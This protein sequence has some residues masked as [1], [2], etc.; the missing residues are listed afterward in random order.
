MP[1]S[2]S[3]SHSSTEPVYAA[4]DLG[5]NSFHMIVV[6]R[7]E[8]GLQVIDRLREMVRLADAIDDDG[9]LDT[10]ATE[11][12]IECLRRF[13]ERLRGL[14]ASHVRAVGT[15]TLRRIGEN[16]D[17][18]SRAEDALGLPIEVI[19]G[20]EEARLIYLGV[21]EDFG[22]SAQRQLVIDIGGGSTEFII[23]QGEETLQLESLEAGCVRVSR[24][25][26]PD[27]QY[28]E[29]A[30]QKALLSVQL[31]VAQ[32]ESQYRDTGWQLCIGSS[33]TFKAIAKVAAAMGLREVGLDLAAIEEIRRQALQAGT[34][35]KLDLPALSSQRRPVFVG[36][37]VVAEAVF[38]QLQIEQMEISRAALR[39][40]LIRD[41]MGRS[42]DHDRRD[43]TVEQFLQRWG[44]D[45]AQAARV[46]A[47]A[48]SLL[49]PWLGDPRLDEQALDWLRWAIALH[50]IG[51]IIAHDGHRKHGAYLV[52]NASMS[53]FSQLDQKMVATLIGNQRRRIDKASMTALGRYQSVATF[54]LLVLRLAVLLNR[55]RQSVDI[56]A[57]RLSHASDERACLQ[58][59]DSLLDDSP[60]T[61]AA[62]QRECHYWRKCDFDLAIPG[63]S[64]D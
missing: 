4:I 52:R 28:T 62:L 10:E 38:R 64:S 12:A 60:L 32:I 18:Q 19:A 61:Q 22:N 6:R 48:D 9:R 40:G 50:E 39:E 51:L 26:F 45:R 13:G 15:N 41:M 56:S 59:P 8:A 25:F 31:K 7:A 42:E 14:K 21:A 37:L 53:G 23:G 20:Y 36:G 43:L 27:G 63:L 35:K 49:A 57:V 29:K 30:Y 5:S 11:R 44:V 16:N 24:R 54:L 1:S 55:S 46:Q 58:L 33:G 34:E 2:N 47:T 17:F 3:S